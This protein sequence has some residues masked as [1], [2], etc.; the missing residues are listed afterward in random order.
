MDAMRAVYDAVTA[1]GFEV[2]QP[3]AEGTGD[4]Y[5][6]FFLVSGRVYTASNAVRRWRTMIQVDL[7]SRLGAGPDVKRLLNALAGAG[8]AIRDYGP[9]TYEDDTRWYHMPVTVEIGESA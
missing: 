8:F 6:S 1:A 4:T 5:C 3:P 2:A 7:W 9:E